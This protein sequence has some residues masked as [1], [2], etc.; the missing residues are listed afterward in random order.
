MKK[1]TCVIL[2]ISVVLVFSGCQQVVT[3]PAD[4]LTLNKW[5]GELE[6]SNTVSLEFDGSVATLSVTLYDKKNAS[7]SGLC[8]LSDSAFVI[9]DA[10]T[11]IPYAFSYIVHFDRVEIVYKENT[12]LLYKS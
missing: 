4:E 3:N 2:C 7:I 10:S 9:H 11:K 12:V 5:V 6:N 8:E 1:L